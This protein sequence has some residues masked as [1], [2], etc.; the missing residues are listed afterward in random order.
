MGREDTGELESQIRGSRHAWDI[1]VISAASLLKLVLVKQNTEEEETLK[2]IRSLLTPIEYTRLDELVDTL[3]TTAKD[4]E[5]STETEYKA[6]PKSNNKAL[7]EKSEKRQ[8]EW[9]EQ[10]V[11]DSHRN[12]I[13]DTFSKKVKDPLISK[14]K[15]MFWNESKSIRVCCTMS[16]DYSNGVYWYAYHPRWNE[17]LSKADEAYCIFGCVDSNKA[18]ALPLELIQKHLEN[19]NKTEPKG[20]D[21]YWHIHI[22]NKDGKMLWLLK[23]SKTIP[24]DEYEIHV[25]M[26]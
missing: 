22:H 12:K 5:Q 8:F 21:H 18:Y 11:L 7:E 24:L 17:F 15:A 16:K 13:I 6:A 1:Q 10:E 9:T 19:L 3:F 14:S 25:E 23:Q 2:K 4:V 26:T 20:K